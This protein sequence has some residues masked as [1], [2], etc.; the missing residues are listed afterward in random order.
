MRNVKS[1][2]VGSLVFVLVA[3]AC[4]DPDHSEDLSHL[5]PTELCQ[6]KC[7]LQ[8]A[9]NCER[10]PANFA[11]SCGLL[12]LAKYDKFP[13]C[14]AQSRTLDACSIQ[15]VHYGCEAGVIRAT[16]QGACASEGLACLSCTGG[17]ITNC[18]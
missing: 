15:R 7:E 9:P 17:D 6:R 11:S 18:L 14:T 12:C 8:A 2:C 16:P 4:G 1:L 5:T 3:A 10:A 13:G